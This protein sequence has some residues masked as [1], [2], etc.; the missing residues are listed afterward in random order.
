MCTL[1]C[2]QFVAESAPGW[3]QPAHVETVAAVAAVAAPATPAEVTVAA[4]AAV[5]AA[6]VVLVAAAAA[7]LP[8]A[9]ADALGAA[10][11]AH[12]ASAAAAAVAAAG[13][14][15]CLSLLWWQCPNTRP[16]GRH[17][18]HIRLLV[19]GR[20]LQGLHSFLQGAHVSLHLA[21]LAQKYS[22]VHTFQGSRRDV[23][24][25]QGTEPRQGSV[26]PVTNLQGFE[27]V[28]TIGLL[29]GAGSS[30]FAANAPQIPPISMMH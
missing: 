15:G 26:L 18:V 30:V 28:L 16:S 21:E 10:S 6:P 3:C 27:D 17:H 7:V 29:L 13:A 4:V 11:V 22:D 24:E 25:V 5:V 9:L 14:G 2:P 12:G 23:A 20:L 19:F 1:H 8:S